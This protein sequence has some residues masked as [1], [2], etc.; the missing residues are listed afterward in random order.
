MGN[1]EKSAAKSKAAE[2]AEFNALLKQPSTV[3]QCDRPVQ[4]GA[5]VYSADAKS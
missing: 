4:K 1:N 5:L 3:S 2:D